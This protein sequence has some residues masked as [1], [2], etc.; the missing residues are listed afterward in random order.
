MGGFG[1]N[2]RATSVET[3]DI[4]PSSISQIVRSYGNIRTQDNVRVSPQISERVVELYADLGDTVRTGQPLA[5]L[6]DTNFRDQV[7]RD[8]AQV[9]QARIALRRDSTEFAR[10]E[11]LYERELISDADLDNA[12]VSLLSSQTNLRSARA[13]LTQSREN[14]L[15]TTIT[16]PIDGVITRRNISTGDLAS[17]GSVAFEI[18]NLVG[19]EMRVF[20]PLADRRLIRNGQSATIRMSGERQ[21]SATGVVSRISPELDP[22]T[23]LAEVVISLVDIDGDILPGSLAEAAVTVRTNEDAIVIPRSAMVENVQTV[24]DPES[25]SIR[26]DR[27]FN[28]FVARGDTIAELRPL[29]TGL[30]QG[31]RI[32]VLGGVSRGERIIVT[33]QGGLEDGSRIRVTGRSRGEEPRRVQRDGNQE[34]NIDN[35][36]PEVQERIRQ[37]RGEGSGATADTQAQ[38][39][40]GAEN[41]PQRQQGSGEGQQR[42]RNQNQ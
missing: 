19:Y 18:S 2:Q 12:R 31:D 4:T 6:R 13:S 36:P 7:L 24:L 35:L 15:F 26:I 34:R 10:A 20:L 29:E 37:A 40:D 3:I 17:S 8:E 25:N 1:G 9:E 11:R 28:V 39:S 33:G 38:R 16:S 14:L 21:H 5:K 41:R 30:Q 22:V 42:Q 23:G 32:E 27:T